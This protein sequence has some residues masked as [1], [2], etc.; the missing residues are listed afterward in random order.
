MM[1]SPFP[2][3][4]QIFA[5]NGNGKNTTATMNYPNGKLAKKL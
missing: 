5:M 4:P 1:A 3:N 2:T